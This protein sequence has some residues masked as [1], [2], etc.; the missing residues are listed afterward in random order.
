MDPEI[1]QPQVDGPEPASEEAPP[2]PDGAVD[3]DKDPEPQ[4]GE[5]QQRA[6][7][8]DD[9]RGG[10]RVLRS[11]LH[12]TQEQLRRLERELS[13][14]RG[15]RSAQPAPQPYYAP[16]Q[17]VDPARERYENMAGTQE[18]ILLALSN[19]G[20]P[21]EKV[22]LLNR[23]WHD[24]ERQK[25]EMII[26]QRLRV[27]QSQQPQAPQQNVEN[28]LLV[29]EYPEIMNNLANSTQAKAEMV[30]LMS[31]GKPSN[32]ATAREACQR[33]QLALGL[34]RK[35][36]PATEAA[37]SR[38]TSVPARAGSGGSGNMFYPTK[39]QLS[40]ARGFTSHLPDLSDGE[41]VRRWVEGVGRPSGLVK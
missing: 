18:A 34:G 6:R 16:Q 9:S 27:Q 32:L 12:E 14:E 41:R 2:L 21:Q 23:Q 39:A 36:A 28:A 10:R 15:R 24:L 17:Q 40:A 7:P 35:P 3:L 38:H 26:D 31:A 20:L 33:V 29:A 8:D 30:R 13:E 1:E 4:S 37:R 22:S 5:A 19:T 25:Q 11:E